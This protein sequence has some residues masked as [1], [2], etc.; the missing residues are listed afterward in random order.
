MWCLFC[1]FSYGFVVGGMYVSVFEVVIK[2]NVEA[3]DL[4]SAWLE[5]EFLEE[6]IANHLL[7]VENIT[8]YGM[9]IIQKD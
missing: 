7:C 5:M 3:D 6:A 2:F 4:K 9:D 1:F 8:D